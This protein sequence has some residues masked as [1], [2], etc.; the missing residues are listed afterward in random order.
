MKSEPIYKYMSVCPQTVTRDRTLGEAK[1]LMKERGFRHLPVVDENA[2]VGLLSLREV[3]LVMAASG[4]DSDMLTVE[5]AMTPEPYLVAPDSDLAEVAREMATRR[6]GS[7]I[8][9]D[10]TSV[11]GV[12]TTV[13][14]LLA[15]ARFAA[16]EGAT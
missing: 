15:L 16:R 7:A 2:I 13:D 3:E 9:V 8:V 6:C 4:P 14:A 11:V 12:F 1:A 10:R 5:F